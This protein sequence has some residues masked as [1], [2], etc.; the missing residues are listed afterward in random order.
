M[1]GWIVAIVIFVILIVLGY[2]AYLGIRVLSNK[3]Q[4]YSHRGTAKRNKG[5]YTDA[6]TDFDRAIQL[7]P[8]YAYAYI[9]RGNAKR[10]L[11]QYF[12]AIADYDKAIRLKPDD[13]TAYDNRG[14]AKHYLGQSF[15]DIADYDKAIRLEPDDAFNAFTYFKWGDSNY[16]LGRIGEAKQDYRTAL[17]LAEQS[18]NEWL[19]ANIEETMRLFFTD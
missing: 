9:C 11:E 3:P 2:I 15:V 12:A 5:N 6:V 7:E 13:A 1:T 18:G 16:K 19:K 4:Y 8:D 10:K 17:K 14:R